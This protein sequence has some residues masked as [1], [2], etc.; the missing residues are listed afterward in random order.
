MTEEIGSPA[1][2]RLAPAPAADAKRP[3]AAGRRR[4][5][6]RLAFLLLALLVAAG[7]GAAWWARR[8][9]PSVHYL[10]VPAARGG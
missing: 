3:V 7:L 1:V 6:H 10:T 8:A 5:R 4:L 9:A 2:L